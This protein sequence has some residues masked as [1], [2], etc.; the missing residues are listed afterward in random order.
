MA[1]RVLIIDVETTGLP[2]KRYELPTNVDNWPYPVQIAWVL[3]KCSHAGRP[4]RI[5]RKSSRL[6]KPDGW[7]VPAETTAIHGISHDTALQHGES[8]LTVMTEVQEVLHHTHAICC[9]NTAFDIPVLISAS[10]RAGIQYDT[11]LVS[12]KPTICTMTIGTP[13]CK[14]VRE[15][16]GKNGVYRRIKPPKLSEMYEYLF[17]RPFV[18]RLHDASEDCRATVEI[19]DYLMI[20]YI[21]QVKS[22][23]PSLF[24]AIE[25]TKVS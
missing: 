6:I 25:L 2:K 1:H 24:H 13:I 22:H 19:L 18:G 12:Q 17:K 9:H 10:I 7:I 4:G 21:R 15:Y 16:T 11:L 14:L 23:C 5:L 3:F 8:L 20:H